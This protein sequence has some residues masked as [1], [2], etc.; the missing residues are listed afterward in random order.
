MSLRLIEVVLPESQGELISRLLDE[1][2]TLGVWR[3]PLPGQLRVRVLV[4]AEHAEPVLDLLER[5]LSTA[6]GYRV[7]LYPVE[8]TLP[9]PE[10]EE[11]PA[12]EETQAPPPPPERISREELY[13]DVA[14]AA[15]VGP[16]F[17]V[18]VVLSTIVAAVGLMRNDVA[19]IIG[20]MV[21]APLLGPNVALALATTLADWKLASRALRASALGAAAGLALAV[22]LPSGSPCSPCSSC[23]SATQT[24]D[25]H[26]FSAIG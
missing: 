26:P 3:E 11:E 21:I 10:E 8:A 5:Q 14:D 7:I 2:P 20:A 6:D 15:K 4:K 17:L 23:S 13:S 18:T 1:K 25:G 24:R 19:V 12:A 22:Q 9:R 16:V